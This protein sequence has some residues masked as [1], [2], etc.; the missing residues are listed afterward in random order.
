MKACSMVTSVAQGDEL[1]SLIPDDGMCEASAKFYAVGVFEGL[2]YMHRRHII[3]RDI[4]Q[5][6]I[7]INEKGYPVLIDFGSG[8][9][10][11]IC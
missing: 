4:K 9:Y 5:Q 10:I 1:E 3:H 8:E 11:Q 7:L 6:N 2:A